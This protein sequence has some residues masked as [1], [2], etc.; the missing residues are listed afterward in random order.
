MKLYHGTDFKSAANISMNGID[1]TKS[2]PYLDFGP[3]FYTTPS[4]DHAA[5]TA[6]NKAL[7]INSVP[8]IVTITL[9]FT[10]EEALNIKTFATRTEEWKDFILA[11]RLYENRLNDYCEPIRNKNGLYDIC[12]GPIA[13]GDVTNVMYKVN[14]GDKAISS[15]KLKD[16]MARS[17]AKDF[18]MQYSF[19]TLRSLGCISDMRCDIV[20]NT[21][22]YS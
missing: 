11:N 18:P 9:D 16:F 8:Y 12:V 4:Y 6:V 13:D 7:R 1:L 10:R 19:H 21:N 15:V 14:S 5:K 20:N 2:K 3:G 22:K 17:I